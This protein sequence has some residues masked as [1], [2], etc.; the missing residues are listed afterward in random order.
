M[1]FVTHL[2]YIFKVI[3]ILFSDFYYLLFLLHV[4][5]KVIELYFFPPVSAGKLFFKDLAL[6]AGNECL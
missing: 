4:D 3:Q 1:Y 2:L 5:A 6:D